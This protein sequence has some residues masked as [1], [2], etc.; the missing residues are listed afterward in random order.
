MQ[1]KVQ[2]STHGISSTRSGNTCRLAENL[3][4]AKISAARLAMTP[5]VDMLDEQMQCEVLAALPLE[6]IGAAEQTCKSWSRLLRG[7]SLSEPIWERV[8]ASAPVHA[9]SSA[10]AAA[11]AATAARSSVTGG[12]AS[13][14]VPVH[15]LFWQGVGRR[16][17]QRAGVLQA[18]W[19]LG[20]CVSEAFPSLHT[21]YVMAMAMHGG[22][23][24]TGGADNAIAL[25]AARAARH[26]SMK[27]GRRDA[28]EHGDAADGGNSSLSGLGSFDDAATSVR[29]R[30]TGEASA[31]L[32]SAAAADGPWDAAVAAAAAAAAAAPS[33]TA[34]A[35]AAVAA[36]PLLP[37][38]QPIMFGLF[39]LGVEGTAAHTKAALRPRV[40]RAHRAQV[41]ALHPHAEHLASC[42]ADGEVLVWSLRDASVVRRHRTFGRVYSLSLGERTIACGG[43]GSQPVRLFDWRDGSLVWEAADADEAPKGVTTCLHRS[44]A[45]LAAGNSDTHSQLR[46][47]DL[48]ANPQSDG[49]ASLRDSFSLPSYVKGVRCVCAPTEQT[50][51]VGTTNGW[52]VHVDLRSGRYEKKGAH[53]DCVNSLAMVGGA[54]ILCSAGDDKVIRIS[55]MRGGAFSPLGSHKLRSVVYSLCADDE[56]IYA[57]VEGGDI[58]TFDYSAEANP[59]RSAAGGNEGGF[60]SEQKQALAAAMAGAR[61]SAGQRRAG[62]GDRLGFG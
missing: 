7:S 37:L 16:L 30:R 12:G 6:D 10:A 13:S 18:H 45:L 38:Q 46:V 41:L 54:P 36:F 34:D 4:S 47:W 3:A 9:V 42:S 48:R 56:A 49:D 53:A 25:T 50:L 5:V 61:S 44:G 52:L 59:L 26:A 21:E 40:L 33:A 1:Q 20:T 35:P 55:D 28:S 19:R 15:P 62:E 51:I 58:K 11:A 14:S 31:H 24:I 8:V 57:A 60:T 22:V 27:R 32:G 39:D 2:N 17:Q 23:L 43:E 29:L